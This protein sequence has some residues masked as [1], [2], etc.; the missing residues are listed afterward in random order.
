MGDKETAALV[1]ENRPV[2]LQKLVSSPVSGAYRKGA[3]LAAHDGFA[4]PK[5][6]EFD[7]RNLG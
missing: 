6:R 3:T 1:K 5:W 4:R 2:Y 7:G